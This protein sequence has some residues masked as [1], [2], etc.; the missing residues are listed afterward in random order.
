MKVYVSH[1]LSR[2]SRELKSRGYDIISEKDGVFD[3]VICNLKDGEL[4][5]LNI[6]SNI[7]VGETIIIDCGRKN[8]NDIEY[9]L[10]NR[11]SNNGIS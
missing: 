11:S 1:E 8:I 4:N 2:V 3:A 9:I 10:N 6:N 7:K 5:E